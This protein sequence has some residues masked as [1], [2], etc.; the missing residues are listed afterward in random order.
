M[1]VAATHA[2]AQLRICGMD[3]STYG[4]LCVGGGGHARVGAHVLTG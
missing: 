4:S 3:M 1:G 2:R